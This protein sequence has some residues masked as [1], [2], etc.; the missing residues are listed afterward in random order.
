[1]HRK[2]HIPVAIA[3]LLV[4]L[5]AGC[6][7]E[8][9]RTEKPGPDWSR[10]LYLGRAT[11][12]QPPALQVDAQKHI[13]VAWYGGDVYYAHL[14]AEA[15]ILTNTALDLEPPN[16]RRPQLLVDGQDQVHL[17]WLARRGNVQLLYHCLVGPAGE[18]TEPVLLSQEETN[19]TSFQIYLATDET[20]D[21]VWASEDDSK[22]KAIVHAAFDRPGET[23][24]L[25][26]GVIDPYVLVDRSGTTHLAWMEERGLTARTIYYAAINGDLDN[27]G[28][29]AIPGTRLVDFEYG[30]GAVYYGPVIGL[31]SKT[32]Y[33]LWAEQNLGGGLTP[34]AAFSHYVAFPFGAP[35]TLRPQTIG[36]PDNARPEYE[37]Y[38]SAYGLDELDLLSPVDLRYGSDFVSSPA[39]V[40][41][42]TS[43][44][45][46]ALSLMT[47]SQAS[48]EIQLATTVLAGG[49]Q[50]GYQ[51][52]SKTP[53]ASLMPTLVSD[54]DQNLH[55]A[56]IDTAGFREYD[57]YYATLAP[58]ARRWLDRTSTDD[59][60]LG[61]AGIIFGI[62]SG[63]GLLPIAGVWSF[64]PTVWIVLFYIFSGKEELERRG[65]RIGL[66]VGIVMYVGMK[67]LLL[68]GLFAGTPFLPLVP[69]AWAVV[70]GIAVPA[71]ILLLALL[72][73]YF[74]ARRAERATIFRA[75]FIFVLV[76]VVL[77]LVLYAPGFFGRA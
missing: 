17:A 8:S 52:A 26:G 13:H 24:V 77:T 44:L 47:A 59:L 25:V 46:V 1:M 32:V 39:T 35:A 63:V 30:E 42:Q 64:P 41:S 53:N 16:P 73:V 60:V 70:I 48:S 51:L 75:F 12:R 5:L 74:Y 49:Q 50:V 10:A 69:P 7:V 4:I 76:D 55:L 40:S 66:A 45:P 36:L 15:H 3:L 33:V 58:Q 27:L 18:T 38:S 37:A 62:L 56:W 34:T 68:P 9:D 20:A 72:A 61:A 28:E 21:I 29:R 67:I 54:A 2:R 57:V 31:D 43:E 71:V 6:N 22:N 65:A 23:T 14:D 19:V 11:L